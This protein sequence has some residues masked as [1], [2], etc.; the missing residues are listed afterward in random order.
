MKKTEKTNW[1]GGWTEQKLEAFEKYVSVYLTIMLNQRKKYNGWPQKI[2]YFDGFAGSGNRNV[3]DEINNNN[4]TIPLISLNIQQIE[5]KLYQGSAERVLSL[6]KKFDEYYF[7]D[8]NRNALLSLRDKVSTLCDNNCH[9]ISEDVN[10]VLS[11]F[12]KKL[13]SKDVSL[14]L[15]D[16]FGMQVKW[17]S[18]EQF[19]NKR[20]DIWILV[21][22]GVIINRLLDKKGELKN[23]TILEDFFGMTEEE[24]KNEFY[25]EEQ[26]QTLFGEETTIK[27]IPDAIPKIANLYV[28]RLKDIWKYVTEKPLVLYNSKNVPIYHFIFASNNK[29]ANKIATQIVGD[30]Q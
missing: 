22:S 5:T 6:E 29:V 28:K 24:I 25:K 2:I 8:I 21:P 13:T 18:I 26:T 7:V 17:A 3:E 30:N 14:I 27:K 11:V 19:K 9:F 12:A 16:P 23:I 1:G 15:L 10:E 20:V 4:N